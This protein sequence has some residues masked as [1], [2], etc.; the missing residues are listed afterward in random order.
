MARQ[1]A[2]YNERYIDRYDLRSGEY[3]RE[4]TGTYGYY[5]S[6]SS[7]APKYDTPRHRGRVLQMPAR[8]RREQTAK[9]VVPV[10]SPVKA[11]AVVFVVAMM[12]ASLAA[13][14]S[15]DAKINEVN[16]SIIN[17]D[18][19]ISRQQSQIITLK[20]D[21]E[22]SMSI[23]NIEEYAINELGMQKVSR[24]QVEYIRLNTED[25]IEGATGKESLL[26]KLKDLLK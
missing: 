9:Y 24:N 19:Q 18:E 11:I 5:P 26:D 20:M 2:R 8:S 7:A 3:A 13:V 6:R 25:K 16:N 17:L 4:R 10:H 23:K 1:S 14:L 22:E 21:I 15:T 12:V